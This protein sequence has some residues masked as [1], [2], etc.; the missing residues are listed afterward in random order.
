M[1]G[2]A[3]ALPPLSQVAGALRTTTERL[4][5][6]ISAPAAQAPAWTELEWDIARAASAMHGISS[7]LCGALRWRGPHGWGQFLREQQSQSVAR[8]VHI[9][10]V[11]DSIDWHSRR[12]GTAF[13]ALKGAALHAGGFYAA[14][15]RPMGD[16][17]L[18]LLEGDAAAAARV[19]EAC[20]YTTAFSTQ[21]HQVFRPKLTKVAG[22]H[23]FGE[24]IDNPIKIE[25]HAKIAEPLP[26][27]MTDITRFLVPRAVHPGLN[28]YPSAASLMMHLLLHAAG[29]IRARALRFIQLHDIAQ[30]AVRF[31][32]ADWDELLAARPNERGLWW[33]SAP[34]ILT[35]RYYPQAIPVQL[36]AR[37]G[38]ECPWLLERRARRQAVTDVS[39]SNIRIEAFPGVEWS[40][41]PREAVAFMRS[42][43][44]PSREALSEL[45][46]AD[47]Q[48]P[49][50]ST[51]AWYGISHGAR[52]LR[53]V[54]SRPPRV[55][56]LLSVR[57]AL[58]HEG[59]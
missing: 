44:W 38:A 35:A 14:G 31:N 53:W 12:T 18:L 55:Q 52:I 17:D 39:W 56:T 27:M 5:R 26:V 50:S 40:R 9:S 48:I 7:L 42:R 25:L 41:T 37:L 10:T 23:C 21:R 19:L 6:E 28:A 13:V 29:N 8:H 45:K 22:A 16:I 11:L 32:G 49:N 51:V 57:A 58:A 20:G 47:A 43:I 15:E 33:A 46:E 24:H 2:A 3:V 34:L 1:T 59:R 4:V 36:C 30:L 54:F